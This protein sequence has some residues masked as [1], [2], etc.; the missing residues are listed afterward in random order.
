QGVTFAL[1]ILL[2]SLYYS[3]AIRSSGLWIP[4]C[5]NI[6][7]YSA[8][9]VKFIFDFSLSFTKTRWIKFVTTT[10]TF[11]A[12]LVMGYLV[13]KNH[14]TGI[15]YDDIQRV[16]LI[17]ELILSSVYGTFCGHGLG[18]GAAKWSKGW[19]ERGMHDDQAT[20][21]SLTIAIAVISSA[22]YIAV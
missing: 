3:L 6:S 7:Y 21:I 8:L 10:I 16:W 9:T 15:G 2:S 13:A 22:F 12:S 5:W 4:L 18:R 1:G 17:P 19:T 14:S 20:F 11:T